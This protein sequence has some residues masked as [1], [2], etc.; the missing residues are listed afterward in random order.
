VRRNLRHGPRTRFA[1]ARVVPLIERLMQAL[2]RMLMQG[3]A[4]SLN[5]KG[6]HGWVYDGAVWFVCARIAD[7]VRAY[8]EQNESAEA[9][10]PKDKND[11]LFDVWQDYGAIET[12]P[13]TGGAVWTVIVECD[14]WTSPPLTVLKFPLQRLFAAPAD[15]PAPLKGRLIVQSKA[16]P[17]SSAPA[18]VAAAPP[19]DA[20]PVEP[21]A[22]TV[23]RAQTDA[24]RAGEPAGAGVS[25]PGAAVRAQ[26]ASPPERVGDVPDPESRLP[27]AVESPSPAAPLLSDYATDGA[28]RGDSE[29][30]A[31]AQ[32]P[33]PS[34][35][36]DAPPAAAA[37][38]PDDGLLAAHEAAHAEPARPASAPAGDA[39]SAPRHA[40]DA[41]ADATLRKAP[42]LAIRF[43]NWV[44]AGVGSG[45]IR[46]NESGS[47][48]H[49]CDRGALLLTP[50][51]FRRFVQQHA[52]A[53]DGPLAAALAEGEDK[54]IA[55]VQSALR[56]AGWTVRNG[57][58]NIHYYTFPKSD[59]SASRRSSF[60]L[61]GVPHLF[62]NPVP[63]PNPRLQRMPEPP[64]R[65]QLAPK[66]RAAARVA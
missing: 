54:A 64:K 7:D 2:R 10:P 13:D 39:L 37:A 12:N 21:P 61:I 16:A 55:R 48:V 41:A 14:G 43:M 60:V 19:V 66:P 56:K 36:A 18:P 26:A 5:R 30:S 38:P 51:T 8:L 44:A 1:S 52:G 35:P 28:L 27:L 63:R 17:A 62:W 3:G 49:F 11:R 34:A 23:D 4:L 40:F 42:E 9:L 57:D 58:Q 24:H 33:R 15:Y 31:A 6:A 29:G 20:A 53:A 46:H 47:L 59:G 25:Q 32:P 45:E 22:V 50:E 65:L